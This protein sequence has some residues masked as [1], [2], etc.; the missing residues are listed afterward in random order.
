C[1]TDT[2]VA[3]G[4]RS[5]PLAPL[6]V[7]ESPAR[8]AVTPCGSST[9]A[10]A[11]RDILTSLLTRAGYAA[12]GDDAQHLAT[13]PGGARLAVGHDAL[14]RR[15]D[16]GA[17]ATEDLRQLILAAVDPQARTADALEAVD[18]RAAL[19]IF[20]P[21][22]QARLAAIGIETEIADVA[23]LLQHLDDGGLQARGGELHFVLARGL[24]VADAGQQVGD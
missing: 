6:M 8:V 19:V 5:D 4:R 23:L 7:M 2:P 11:I 14:R 21:D 13:V 15:D 1:T 17:H 18:H 9:G 24:A 20:Q 3:S 10:L 16:H 22:R 12:S